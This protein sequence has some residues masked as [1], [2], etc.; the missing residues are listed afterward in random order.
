MLYD[1]AATGG[2]FR[3]AD[4]RTSFLQRLPGSRRW[5]HAYTALMPMA[6]ESFDTGAFDT[7]LSLSASFAK[8]IVTRP[9]TRHICYCLTPPRF[10]WDDSHR[11]VRRFS[12]PPLFR[13]ASP[14]LLSYLR[15]WDRQ[16][17]DRVDEFVAISRCV[18]ERIGKYYGRESSVLYPPVNVEVFSRNPERSPGDYFLMVG[19]L[20]A[21]KQFEIGIQAA[22]RLGI[23]LVIVGT[24]AQERRL[25]HLAGPTVSFVGRVN[26]DALVE[27]YVGARA[28]LF[29]QE[30]DFGIVPV[31]AMAAGRPVI[32]YRGGG[33]QETV[34]HG[35]TGL[36]F[37]EQTSESLAEAL[38]RFDRSSFDPRRCRA[39]AREFDVSHFISRMEAIF[40]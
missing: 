30:E 27:L 15:V 16:A 19:R 17:A 1:A 9:D 40:G 26:D 31:E 36:L 25:R 12:L 13:F 14:L 32:A 2:V 18:Q 3:E 34:L 10:L 20:V 28:V 11:F 37:D 4:M 33:A 38:E 5:H 21:Y 8:G 35:E 39:Q 24:G 29:P 6:A 23:P 22:N 7:V